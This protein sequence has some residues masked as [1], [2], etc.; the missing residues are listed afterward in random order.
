MGRRDPKFV[1]HDPRRGGRYMVQLDRRGREA[2]DVCAEGW[3]YWRAEDRRYFRDEALSPGLVRAAL[4]AQGRRGY[5]GLWP[6]SKR[7]VPSLPQGCEVI[8][9]RRESVGGTIALND[10]VIQRFRA[11]IEPL[12][13]RGVY[14]CLASGDA[15]AAD[16]FAQDVDEIEPAFFLR[17]RE[18]IA[19]IFGFNH[20]YAE[21][22]AYLRITPSVDR[23]LQSLDMTTRPYRR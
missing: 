23:I 13:E 6:C 22:E 2:F 10:G 4:S 11:A 17:R 9:E 19:A 18:G 14:E 7:E 16:L 12:G 1:Q 3:V 5:F 8:E 15:D 20:D 21:V